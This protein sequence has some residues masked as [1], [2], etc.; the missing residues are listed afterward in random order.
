MQQAAHEAAI[1]PS[2]VWLG[3]ADRIGVFL[4]EVAPPDATAMGVEGAAF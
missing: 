3:L 4:P 1:T 2:V